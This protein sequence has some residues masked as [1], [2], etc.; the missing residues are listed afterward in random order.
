MGDAGRMHRLSARRGMSIPSDIEIIDP[1]Q[2]DQRYIDAMVELRG[3]Q[4]AER[5]AGRRATARLRWCWA[6]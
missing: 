2:I 4:G 6:P 5:R 3:A 1:A